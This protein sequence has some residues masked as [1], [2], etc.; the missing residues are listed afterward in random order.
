MMVADVLKNFYLMIPV[1]VVDQMRTL[2]KNNQPRRL[3]NSAGFPSDFWV[4]L[5]LLEMDFHF[6]STN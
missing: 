2:L 6:P 5:G 3:L 4:S 1:L